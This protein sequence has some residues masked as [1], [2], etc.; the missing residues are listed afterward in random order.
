MS[1]AQSIYIDNMMKI[2][3]KGPGCSSYNRFNYIRI[4]KE[5]DYNIPLDAT[6]DD[7]LTG[8][9][10]IGQELYKEYGEKLRPFLNNKITSY[11]H[12][13]NIK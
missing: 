4:Q 3:C 6:D 10:S 11:K 8:L 9:S 5:L 12:F 1:S 13:A 7:I 2:F